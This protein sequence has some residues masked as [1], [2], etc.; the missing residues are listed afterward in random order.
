MSVNRVYYDSENV[1]ITE[2]NIAGHKTAAE[3][4]GARQVRPVEK[5]EEEKMEEANETVEKIKVEV[6]KL[7]EGYIGEVPK[8]SLD[9]GIIGVGGAGN[10][11][12]DAFAK[13]GYDAMLVNLTDRDYSHLT[14]TP[15]DEFSRIELIVGAGGAGKNPDVGADAVREYANA[16]TKK[17]SRK[18]NNKEFIFVAAGLGGGTGSLGGVLV[19]EIAASLGV[20]VGMIITLPRKNEGTDE[21]VNCLRGLQEVA[22]HRG[23]KSIVVIDNQR[24]LESLSGQVDSDFWGQA[25]DEIVRLFDSFNRWSAVPSNTA[26]D[27]E[28]YKKCLMTPGFLVLGRSSIANSNVGADRS[29]AQ[30]RDAVASIDKG[31]LAGGFDYKT[32]VRAAGMIIKPSDLDYAHSFEE[33]LFN[34]LKDQIGSGGLNRGIYMNKDATGSVLVN[35]MLA[36]MRLPESRVNEL[37]T[38]AKAEASDMSQKVRQR[39]T[40]TF[41][42]DIPTDINSISGNVGRDGGKS[43]GLGRRK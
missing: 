27:A 30:L 39:Q 38:E 31:F 28:D 36:G 7:A 37:V 14:N 2:L 32:A 40:E 4:R 18:F 12:A 42:L 16:L 33:M 26:F 41:T 15:D 17:I 35:T 24:V 8:R 22:N 9:I 13:A 20:P 10:H 23:I 43:S 19:A 29:E 3:L 1:S 21:K 6:A 11:I 25:N 5:L 34:H